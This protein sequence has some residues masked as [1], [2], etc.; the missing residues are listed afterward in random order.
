MQA[1][2]SESSLRAQGDELVK[3]PVCAKECCGGKGGGGGGGGG[4]R[5]LVMP[6]PTDQQQAQHT[7]TD[8]QPS[9]NGPFLFYGPF[10]L[11]NLLVYK[12]EQTMGSNCS[13]PIILTSHMTLNVGPQ[14]QTRVAYDNST[15]HAINTRY[16]QGDMLTYI[17]NCFYEAL[18]LCH[19]SAL[20]QTAS[21]RRSMHSG[22]LKIKYNA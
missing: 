5:I 18:V 10:S 13:R 14:Q 2:G 20:S 1:P 15:W 7:D 8:T 3:Y 4:G 17:T 12:H 19:T 6:R 9:T 16:H 21:K 22:Q 11:Y